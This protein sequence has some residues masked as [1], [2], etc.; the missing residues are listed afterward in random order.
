MKMSVFR[1]KNGMCD[2][3]SPQC[4]SAAARRALAGCIMASRFVETQKTRLER[5]A[6]DFLSMGVFS[7]IQK[8]LV[9]M[10][11]PCRLS[12]CAGVPVERR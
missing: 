5:P 4:V 12:V 9:R 2:G 1:E 3:A 8:K 6:A 7:L 11:A 10:V